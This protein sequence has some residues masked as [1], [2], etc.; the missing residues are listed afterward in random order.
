MLLFE[1]VFSGSYTKTHLFVEIPFSDDVKSRQCRHGNPCKGRHLGISRD[2]VTT[3]EETVPTR[4]KS[5]TEAAVFRR[6][7]KGCFFAPTR[8]LRWWLFASLLTGIPVNFHFVTGIPVGGVDPRWFQWFL[9]G[10]TMFNPFIWGRW[11]PCR[12]I[13]FHIYWNLQLVIVGL[14]EICKRKGKLT[15]VPPRIPLKDERKICNPSTVI[16]LY[17]KG[18]S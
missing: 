14:M 17:Y 6:D 12:L 16:I 5:T 18:V 8:V 7:V 3:L 9:G 4:R 11:N 15:A 2:K 10:S 1:G 13:F